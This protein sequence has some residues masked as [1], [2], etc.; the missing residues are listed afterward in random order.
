MEKKR[1]DNTIEINS[2]KL[3]CSVDVYIF[4][5]E[6]HMTAYCPSLDLATTGTDFQDAVKNFYECLQLHVECCL[7]MGTFEEDLKEHGWK[8]S[9]KRIAPPPFRT[10]LKNRQLSGLLQ[11]SINYERISA[12]LRIAALA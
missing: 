9:E 2:D 10:Q 8:I 7:E 12:P 6:D 5:E 4:K 3:R 1:R 11:S